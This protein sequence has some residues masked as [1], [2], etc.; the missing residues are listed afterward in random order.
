M[1]NHNVCQAKNVANTFIVKTT[2]E[3]VSSM[4]IPV[5]VAHETDIFVYIII[6]Q[7]TV[8]ILVVSMPLS[9]IHGHTKCALQ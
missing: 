6:S 7:A 2:I 4:S 8:L 9:C 5:V 1:A 3:L